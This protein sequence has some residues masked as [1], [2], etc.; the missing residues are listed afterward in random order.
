MIVNILNT[1]NHKIPQKSYETDAG[2]DI[3]ATSDPVIVGDKCFGFYKEA[4]RSVDYIEYETDLHIQWTEWPFDKYEMFHTLV[5][6]RS[7]IRNKNLILSNSIGLI[8]S[9]YTGQI[10]VN[11]KYIF[12]PNDLVIMDG[13]KIITI[14]DQKIYQKGDKIA[15]L[16]FQPTFS[17]KFVVVDSLKETKRKDCGFG[18]TG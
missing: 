7:S 16:V 12:Q 2:Y 8:D 3:I 17:V 10:K 9:D 6:P 14:N 18:S 1:R 5:F 11:F 4:W 13:E 15:Q